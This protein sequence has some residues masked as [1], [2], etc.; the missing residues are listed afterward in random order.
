MAAN[1]CL[2]ELEIDPHSFDPDKNYYCNGM[3]DAIG[4]KAVVQDECCGGLI[5]PNFKTGRLNYCPWCGKQ[6]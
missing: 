4:L 2:E 6:V 3:T 1:A 5:I